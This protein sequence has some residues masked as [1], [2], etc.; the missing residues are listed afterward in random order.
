[1]R[2]KQSRTV[3]KFLSS[4]YKDNYNTR[5]CFFW[6]FHQ[7]LYIYISKVASKRFL[8]IDWWFSYYIINH[9]IYTYIYIYIY[10][11]TYTCISS[12][13]SSSSC[14]AISTD[15]PE[16]LSQHLPIIKCFRQ[17]L[18]TTSRI[19]TELLYVESSWT[20]CICSSMWRGPLEYITYELVL[21]SPAVLRV[22]GSFNFDSF[23]D[24]W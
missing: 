10:I 3:F 13:S 5:I 21:T 19:G 4:S 16:S 18:R 6:L 23:R 17:I 8:K 9:N 1:M 24:W 20:S 11:Y 12:P 2:C 15:I 14:H 22:S 7:K